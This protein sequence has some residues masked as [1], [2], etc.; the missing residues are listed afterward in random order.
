MPNPHPWSKWFWSDWKNDPNLCRCSK[1]AKGFWI[2]CLALMHECEDRG[3]LA[4]NGVAWCDEDIANAV[5][6]DNCENLACLRELLDKGV[7][8][9]DEAGAVYS[10]RM[11]RD[12]ELSIVR[13]DAGR[14]GGRSKSEAKAKQT[15]S[16]SDSDSPSPS[17]GVRGCKGKGGCTEAEAEAIYR[18]YPRKVKLQPAVK[19]IRKAV[20]ELAT[21]QDDPLA[22]LQERVTAYAASP[23]GQKPPPGESD[24]RPHPPTWFNQGRYDDDPEEWSIPNG[25]RASTKPNGHAAPQPR[26]AGQRERDRGEYASDPGQ[27]RLL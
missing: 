14:V 15:L 20:E 23:A 6:G 11:V 7:A 12:A 19:A 4:T 26:V 9:R 2:D 27:A 10:R 13:A 21:R 25:H 3:V 16:D 22:W 5:P 18:L 24:Y 17:F 8:S 1:A